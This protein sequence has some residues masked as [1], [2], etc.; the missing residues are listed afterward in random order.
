MAN[1]TEV[2][3]PSMCQQLILVCKNILFSVLL[4]PDYCSQVRNRCTQFSHKPIN[5]CKDL[6]HPAVI[7]IMF[8][9][10][11]DESFRSRHICPSN[12]VC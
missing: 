2:Q 8:D 7:C 1:N 6:N 12:N 11:G 9:S 10:S 3:I 4:L 5:G